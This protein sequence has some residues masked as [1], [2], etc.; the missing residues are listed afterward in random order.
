MYTKVLNTWHYKENELIEL[1]GAVWELV[2]F[3]VE[4]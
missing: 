1:W 4:G 3:Q 2:E